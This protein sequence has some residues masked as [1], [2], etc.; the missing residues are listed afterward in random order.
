MGGGWWVKEVPAGEEK[1]HLYI[2]KQNKKKKKTVCAHFQGDEAVKDQF[3]VLENK[4]PFLPCISIG[5]FWHFT[6]SPL[7]H[8]FTIFFFFYIYVRGHHEEG[9]Q[10]S[11]GGHVS[12]DCWSP[13]V[14]AAGYIKS[15]DR[16][17]PSLFPPHIPH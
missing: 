12:L 9:G 6:S 2:Y 10:F 7:S 14:T 4:F 15:Q 11:P 5:D 1:T 16:T 3:S 13:P 17:L 8:F